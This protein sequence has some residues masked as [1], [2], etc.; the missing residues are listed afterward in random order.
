MKMN[1]DL[2]AI[3]SYLCA[4]GYVIKNPEDQKHKYYRIGLRNTNLLL[5]KDF[6][7]KFYRYFKIRP[8]LREGERCSF[9]NKEIYF[10]FTKTFGS[11]YCSEWTMPELDK[12]LV[13]FWLRAF[14]DCEG[15]VACNSHQNRQ[16][17]ADSINKKGLNQIQVAL[18]NLGI[19]SKIQVR[20][21]KKISC[22]HIYGKENL[23]KFKEK[24]GFLHPRKKDKLDLCLND[25]VNY[26]WSFP[27]DK[28]KLKEFICSL[29]KERAKVRKGRGTM[30]I[31]SNKEFNLKRL[32][33]ELSRLFNIESKLGKRVNGIGT[34]YFELSINKKEDVKKAVNL[35]LLNEEEKKKWLELKK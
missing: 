27:K 22:L 35:N 15:W 17:G 10:K 34:T 1:K 33:K 26:T 16:I 25:F 21:K 28:P 13:R 2:A 5:L 32:Q 8:V 11:F 7:E 18:K 30:R 14:F 19:E 12:E 20:K 29:I 31:I 4:D 23:I 6:Q 3:H 9:Q 24:I